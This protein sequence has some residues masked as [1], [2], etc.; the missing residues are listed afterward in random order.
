MIEEAFGIACLSSIISVMS[1]VVQKSKFVLGIKRLK[2][3]D[4][5]LCLGFWLGFLFSIFTGDNLWHSLMTGSVSAVF[6]FF[7]VKIALR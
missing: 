6:S 4:C 3:L 5:E 7:I 2:P 1:G